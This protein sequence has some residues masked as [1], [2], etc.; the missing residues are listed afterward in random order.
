[1]PKKERKQNKTTTTT[2]LEFYAI[3]DLNT[4]TDQSYLHHAYGR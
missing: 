2:T 3:I 1:M 4:T